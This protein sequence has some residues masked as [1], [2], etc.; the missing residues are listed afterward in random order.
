MINNRASS[1]AQRCELHIHEMV[2]GKYIVKRVVGY[3]EDVIKYKVDYIGQ[4]CILKLF[5]VWQDDP[6]TQQL[7]GIRFKSEISSCRINSSYLE[8]IVGEGKIFGNPYII[9]PCIN[10]TDLSR[11]IS[12]K[13]RVDN[14]RI[15][16]QILYGLRDLHCN[17]KVHCSLMPENVRVSQSGNVQITNY[18]TIGD[19]GKIIED[20]HRSRHIDKSVAYLAPEYFK[21][22][23]CATIL[24]AADIFSFGVIAFQLLTGELPFGNVGSEVEM[25]TYQ[26]KAGSGMWKKLLLSRTSNKEKWTELFDGC[27]NPIPEERPTAEKAIEILTGDPVQDEPA[28]KYHHKAISGVM[29]K[30]VQGEEY[31]KV[32]RL[33]ELAGGVRR[34]LTVGREDKNVFNIISIVEQATSYISRN[35]CTIELDDHTNEWYLRDGQWN[36]V[37]TKNWLRSLNGTYLNSQTITDEG[38]KISIGDIISVG[39]VKLRVEGY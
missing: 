34:I 14:V 36:K 13:K 10:S 5:K 39:D 9:T 22:D 30:V 3:G 6:H 26:S 33:N 23:H 11:I 25:N 35:H 18:V 38:V 32:Y 15:L 19:R 2:D 21:K 1:A 28:C 24:P 20:R 27:F 17:G 16:V 12:N 29:L 31:G 8:P 7:I 4:E 37:D